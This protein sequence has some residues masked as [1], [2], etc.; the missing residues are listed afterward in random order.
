MV[1]EVDAFIGPSQFVIDVHHK[2]GFPQPI[3]R[4]PYF[5]PDTELSKALEP[6]E[7]LEIV[8]PYFLFVGRL[9]KIKGVQVLIEAFRHYRN[10]NLLIAGTGTYRETLEEMADGLPHVRFLGM[11]DHAKLRP[12]YQQAIATIMPSLCYETFGWPIL[13]SLMTK[14]PVIVP[15]LGALPEIVRAT[16]GGLVYD[17]REG[18]VEKMEELRGQ[19]EWRDELGR[20]G[21][22]NALEKYSEAHH[23]GLYHQLI[24][25][26]MAT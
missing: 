21:Y 12:L 23:I 6:V 7:A 1:K 5:L 26:L 25:E 2:H 20:R 9:E 16:Q 13:E 11:L 24:T 3:R 17:D 22:Q 10:A 15:D 18:L 14:T 8:E 19:P 4:I